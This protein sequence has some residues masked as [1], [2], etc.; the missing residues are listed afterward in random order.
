MSVRSTRIQETGVSALNAKHQRFCSFSCS[1]AT[2]PQHSFG[3]PEKGTDLLNDI[4]GETAAFQKNAEHIKR[5]CLRSDSQRGFLNRDI[6]LC[7]KFIEKSLL[8][9]PVRCVSCLGNGVFFSQRIDGS[10]HLRCV[11][12]II[13]ILGQKRVGI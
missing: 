6:M 10:Y 11:A 1:T 13:G 8:L 3:L 9:F 4:V 2:P 7:Q 12:R 5:V